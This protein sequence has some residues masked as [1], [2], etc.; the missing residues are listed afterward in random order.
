MGKLKER[1]NMCIQ[2]NGDFLNKKFVGICAI[3][4]T[5]CSHSLKTYGTLCIYSTMSIRDIFIYNGLLMWGRG[6][7]NHPVKGIRCDYRLLILF[8]TYVSG[9]FSLEPS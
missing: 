3:V 4:C 7:R 9:P 8:L 6:G 2:C 5:F 1:A